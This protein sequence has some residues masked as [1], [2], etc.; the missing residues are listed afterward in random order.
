MISGEARIVNFEKLLS[1][2]Q[3]LPDRMLR[4]LEQELVIGANELRNRIINSMDTTPKTGRTYPRWGGKKFHIASSPGNPPAVDTG[5]LKQSIIM[6]A[7]LPGEVE[8][9][10]T[11]TEPPY[12]AYLEEGTSRMAARPWLEPALDAVTPRIEENIKQRILKA[13]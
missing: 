7:R 10:S 3:A 6:D 11:I 9:G 13:I 4:A 2:F 12:P 5:N 1:Q 8:V